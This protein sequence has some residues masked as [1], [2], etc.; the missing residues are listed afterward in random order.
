M[1][2]DLD[3]LDR[4][5]AAFM[6]H[7]GTTALRVSLA[8][9]FVWFGLLKPL[10]LSPAEPLV[11]ATVQ[12]LPLLDPGTW[13]S[14]I[15]WWEVAIGITFLSRA[16]VRVAIAL[17]TLQMVG[18]FMPLVILPQVTFQPGGMPYALTMEG[19]YIVKNLVIIAAALVVGGTVR[20]PRHP[21]A[22]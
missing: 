10:G 9:I 22:R 11:K 18:T 17:L 13:V 15:G 16:T 5:I 7:W 2:L 14:A 12:W 4:G 21:P 3:A 6:R 20:Q 19:Q 8:L 1:K